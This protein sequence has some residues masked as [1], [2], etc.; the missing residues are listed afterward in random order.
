MIPQ[1]LLNWTLFAH[2][3]QM[4]VLEYVF[5]V[6]VSL[7]VGSFLNVVVYRLP[8]MM[9]R[10]WQAAIAEAVNNPN[11]YR[12]PDAQENPTDEVFNLAVPRSACPHCNHQITWYEN[13]PV[14]SYLFLRGKCSECHVPISLRYPMI[15]L[16]MGLLGV[17]IVY[18]VGFSLTGLA[19]LLFVSTMV[20][21]ALIDFD[22][23]ILPDSIT[24]PFIWLGMVFHVVHILPILTVEQSLVGAMMGYLS[25]WSVYWAYK[26][27]RNKE[28]L[29]YGDFKLLA[30]VGAWGGALILPQVILIA[31]P[32]FLLGVM[33]VHFCKGGWDTQRAAPFGPPLAIAGMMMVLWEY[34]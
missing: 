29:G 34:I 11:G 27:V 20:T 3:P 13:L 30:V 16:T 9:D 28:G 18:L 5:G 14:I 26:L 32:L 7:L 31:A 25:L 17:L 4:L 1:E 10:K 12:F 24:L 23:M 21:L 6:T 15:E 19:L 8:I 2:V 33:Y 22:H